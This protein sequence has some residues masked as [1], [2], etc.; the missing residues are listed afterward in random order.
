MLMNIALFGATGQTGKEFL[1]IALKEGHSV[2]AL[3]RSPSKLNLQDP[4]LLVMQG[5]VLEYEDIDK[6]VSG[7]DIVVSLFGHVKGSPE[8][9]QTDGTRN[10][11]R[12]IKKT[13]W[14]EFCHFSAVAFLP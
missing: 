1:E 4:S 6:T 7:S 11:L 14:I 12:V 2:K 8:W 3:V 9:L 10:I 13:L 5:D